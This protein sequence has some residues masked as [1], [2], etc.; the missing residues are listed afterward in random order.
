MGGQPAILSQLLEAGATGLLTVTECL[1]QLP[2]HYA[3]EY[4]RR[5]MAEQLVGLGAAVDAADSSGRTPLG[6]AVANLLDTLNY[7][8]DDAAKAADLISR[9]LETVRYLLG[10]GA[11]PNV[12]WSADRRSPLLYASQSSKFGAMT[13]LIQ[14]LLE[15]G[16]DPEQADA[17]GRTPLYIP[18]QLALLDL[19]GQR[20][21]ITLLQDAIAAK[22]QAR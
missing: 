5:A 3:A 22:R 19:A 12:A 8:C 15:A 1:G 10:A 2:L 13:D 4:G 7:R 6:A 11:N 14:A 20:R 17:H 16:A 9:H 21:V 18:C